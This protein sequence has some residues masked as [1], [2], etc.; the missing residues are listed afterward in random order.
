MSICGNNCDNDRNLIGDTLEHW[1]PTGLSI[2]ANE[3]LC[4][5]PSIGNLIEPEALCMSGPVGSTYANLLQRQSLGKVPVSVGRT[6][7]GQDDLWEIY[8]VII[9]QVKP[10]CSKKLIRRALAS[11]AAS[12]EKTRLV[13]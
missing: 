4:C 7:M 1:W 10:P 13:T 2:D 5:V 3:V 11:L 6:Y 9:R 12:G 8:S